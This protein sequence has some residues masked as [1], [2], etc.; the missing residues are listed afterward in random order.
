MRHAHWIAVE[1]RRKILQLAA[2]PT[3]QLLRQERLQTAL[4]TL[5]AINGLVIKRGR[6]DSAGTRT[7]KSLAAFNKGHKA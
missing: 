5:W 3:A 4:S 2:Q 6:F 7:S 1:F